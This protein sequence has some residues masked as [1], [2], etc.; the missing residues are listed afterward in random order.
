LLAGEARGNDD[1]MLEL[2]KPFRPH[3]GRVI[4]LIKAAGIKA[5]KYGPR[6]P[7]RSIENI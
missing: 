1:Q 5:P 6:A 4:Q 7:L 2:L 3:R